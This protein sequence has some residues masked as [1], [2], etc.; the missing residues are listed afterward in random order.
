MGDVMVAR[1]GAEQDAPGQAH[2][3]GT[4][5]PERAMVLGLGG[6]LPMSGQCLVNHN[7]YN[8]H[9][10]R[11]TSERARSAAWPKQSEQGVQR[12]TVCAQGEGEGEGEG[13]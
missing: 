10:H 2:G 13:G 3:Q 11:P 12:N 1:S 5:H 7:E 6:Q 4:R 8:E 9:K